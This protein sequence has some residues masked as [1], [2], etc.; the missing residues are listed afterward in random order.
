MSVVLKLPSWI[1][2]IIGAVFLWLTW[3]PF[4]TGFLLPLALV[5]W[6]IMEHKMTIESKSRLKTTSSLLLGI[7]I[8]NILCTWW[9][10]YASPGGAVAMVLANSLL[11]LIP[12][13]IYR[14]VKRKFGID[15]GLLTFAVSW[16]A[17]EYMQYNWE[18]NF[19]W[20]NL[21]NGFARFPILVQWIEYTGVLGGTAWIFLVSI[22][23]FKYLIKPNSKSLLYSVLSYAIPTL[24][25]VI[26]FYS[27]EEKG[28][29]K[30]VVILQPSLD[31]YTEKFELEPEYISSMMVEM[32]EEL[33][34]SET[35]LLVLPETA[36]P[37]NFEERYADNVKKVEIIQAL[38]KTYPELSIVTGAETYEFVHALKRPTP[39]AR[40]A[41]EGVY[42]DMYNTAIFMGKNRV[43]EFYH[44]AKLVPGPEKVPFL[45][46]FGFLEKLHINIPGSAGSLGS[47][48]EAEVFVSHDS[49]ITAPLICYESVFG[50]YTTD[51]INKGANLLLIITNDA[52]WRETDG[53]R[54]HLLFG[55][56]RA[57][58]T[59]RDIARSANTGI[60]GF[61][62]Q[63][64]EIT[65]KTDWWK[66]VAISG[67]VRLNEEITFYSKYG[68]YI[69]FMSAILLA[70]LLSQFIP[71]IRIVPSAPKN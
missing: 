38:F 32:A 7:M 11:M 23:V 2:S 13:T 29:E 18:G 50:D 64:G 28:I 71:W 15:Y 55:A 31:P 27:Y 14:K 53:H 57:I 10:W 51:F 46:V 16:I 61:I 9:V 58:E 68:D 12:W 62:N 70:L 30:N 37:G 4:N 45:G 44:K 43:P 47:N 26:L 1:L 20:L 35:N 36:L 34:D 54:H 59:R 41:K 21:G 63:R 40:M 65:K 24:I 67:K 6:L 49:I 22:L 5:P 8:W 3:P 52:W 66:R 39:T 19:P 25:S 48:E 42:Y 33:L 69:G 56:M 17:Y 60:S